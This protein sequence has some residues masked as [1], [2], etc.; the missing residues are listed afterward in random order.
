MNQ[1]YARV[2]ERR[3]DGLQADL[4]RILADQSNFLWEVGCG[5]GH[6]LTAYA[7]AHPE[8]LCI[9]IDRASE[10][11]GRAVRKRDRARNTNFHFLRADAM[12]FLQ[13]LPATAR[14]SDLFILF[15]DPWP[16]SRHHKHRILQPDFLT[17][18]AA[19]AAPGCR[20]YFRTDH[21]PYFED[22]RSTIAASSAWELETAPW[23]FE[24]E[25]VFQRRARQH[26]SL[27]ARIR[28]P[29]P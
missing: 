29:P 17:A 12:L 1:D 25:T 14:I 13:A 20:L 26:D 2:I 9:G 6:F 10:R 27:V 21:Q 24:F 28:S 8:K 3:R 18:V 5:H 7:A 15:P 11:I 4:Q 23:P 19:C 22:A 16:K